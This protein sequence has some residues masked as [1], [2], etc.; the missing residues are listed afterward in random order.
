MTYADGLVLLAGGM[1]GA[2]VA[3]QLR[4]PMWPITG[5]I[6]GAAVVHLVAG[7]SAQVPGWWAFVAQVLVG[8]AVGVTVRPGVLRDFRTVAIPGSIAVVVIVGVGVG[9]GVLM[10][11]MGVLDPT[12]AVFGMVPG[13]VGEMVAA[14]TA[15]GADTPLV[16]ALHLARLL[17]VLGA[18]PLFV[19]WARRR[20]G[21]P[22]EDR[23]AD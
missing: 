10:A 21:P 6:A 22:E 5:S 2:V 3:K 19:R 23:P 16:A 12:V 20:A 8:T 14:A 9:S 13:G 1:L 15:L 4:L 17:V 7:G 18:L 11:A